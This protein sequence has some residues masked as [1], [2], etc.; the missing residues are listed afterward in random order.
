[1][2]ESSAGATDRP[3]LFENSGTRKRSLWT[4]NEVADYLQVSERT[5][6]DWVYKRVIP[7]RKAGQALRFC[8]EEIERWSTPKHEE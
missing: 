5:V 3:R 7:F 6:R 8:P 4:V 1:L 2:C